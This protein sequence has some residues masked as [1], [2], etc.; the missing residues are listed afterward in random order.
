MTIQKLW[1]PQGQEFY[2]FATELRNLEIEN[3]NL[4]FPVFC[5]VAQLKL[6]LSDE[7]RERKSSQTQYFQWVPR[8]S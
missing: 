8:N 7:N 3:T 6:S 2:N 4:V 1:A 5:T